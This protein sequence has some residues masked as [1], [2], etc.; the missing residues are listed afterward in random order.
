M[1]DLEKAARPALTEMIMGRRI[2]LD[3]EGQVI[4]A[5]WFVKTAM[6]FALAT[7]RRLVIAPNQ[8]RYLFDHRRPP[9]ETQVWLG[10]RTAA[11]GVAGGLFQSVLLKDRPDEIGERGRAYALTIGVGHLVGVVF[12]HNLPFEMPW[13]RSVGLQQIWPTLGPVE[14]PPKYVFGPFEN[15]ADD[16]AFEKHVTTALASRGITIIRASFLN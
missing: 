6:M 3:K 1:H 16:P 8:Y 7:P 5:R 13:T 14:W 11:E 2:T 15:F 10:I 4:V 12:G 9:P